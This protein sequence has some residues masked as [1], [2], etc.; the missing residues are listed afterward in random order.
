[1]KNVMF[2]IKSIIHNF[3]KSESI[4]FTEIEL[5]INIDSMRCSIQSFAFIYIS[6]IIFFFL[7]F[8][9]YILLYYIIN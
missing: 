8:Y 7:N 6:F 3:M 4:I 2:K 9:Y 5:S 1:M